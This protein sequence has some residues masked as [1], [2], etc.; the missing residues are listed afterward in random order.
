MSKRFLE[1]YKSVDRI[2]EYA[3]DDAVSI[4]QDSKSVKFDE[5]Y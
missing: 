1:N 3:L 5:T 4:L 2:R